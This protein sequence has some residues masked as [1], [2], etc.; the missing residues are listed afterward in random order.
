V[1][2]LKSSIRAKIELPEGFFFV[3]FKRL[4]Q[5]FVEEWRRSVSL[6]EKAVQE[7]DT[8]ESRAERDSKIN[9]L[10]KEVVVSIDGLEDED[11]PVTRDRFLSGDIYNDLQRSIATAYFE[12]QSGAKKN[13]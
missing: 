6:A 1:L 7:S 2:K 13:T 8:D 12:H 11:G 9:Q 5:N 10:F 4:K 3:E